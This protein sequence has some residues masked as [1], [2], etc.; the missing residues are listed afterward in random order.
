M[1]RPTAADMANK[2][3][4]DAAY[5][6]EQF[7]ETEQRRWAVEQAAKVCGSEPY[8]LLSIANDILAF[9]WQNEQAA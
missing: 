5:W 3:E 2:H 7:D 6:R 8:G 1:E 4:R 9:V